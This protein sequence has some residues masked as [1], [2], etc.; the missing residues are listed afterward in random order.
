MKSNESVS[1]GAGDTIDVIALWRL[2]WG[3]KYLIAVI[4]GVFGAVAV[5]LALIATPKFQAQVTV[6]PV[7]DSGLGS[8]AT[9]LAGQFGGLASLAGIDLGT[10]GVA[11]QEA[12]AILESR[13]L[14][15]EFIRRNDLVDELLP[16][17][18][19]QSTLWH[20]VQ[21][22]RDKVVSFSYR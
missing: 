11:V 18:S 12:Q 5:V 7:A 9:R 6:T 1:L 22:F 17:G 19:D 20:A 3:Q 15:E 8:S 21:K 2:L 10:R 13:R 4:A 14:L 16:P